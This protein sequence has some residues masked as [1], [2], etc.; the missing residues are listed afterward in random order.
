MENTTKEWQRKQIGRP[1]LLPSIAQS[2]IVISSA[3]CCYFKMKK[4][5]NSI[6]FSQT[7]AIPYPRIPV[8]I[9]LLPMLLQPISDSHYLEKVIRGKETDSGGTRQ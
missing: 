4:K 3:L 2:Y 7:L 8:E 9:E 5:K 6:V 1:L